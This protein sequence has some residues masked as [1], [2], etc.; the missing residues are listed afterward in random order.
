MDAKKLYCRKASGF[1]MFQDLNP[2]EFKFIR[3]VIEHECLLTPAGKKYINAAL[4]HDFRL[5]QKEVQNGPK[6]VVLYEFLEF[7]LSKFMSNNESEEVLNRWRREPRKTFAEEEGTIFQF[8]E[9]NGYIR[10]DGVSQSILLASIV[11][12]TPLAKTEER[13]LFILDWTSYL[14]KHLEDYYEIIKST[15][16]TELKLIFDILANELTSSQFEVMRHYIFKGWNTYY[17]YTSAEYEALTIAL[18]NIQEN[19]SLKSRINEVMDNTLF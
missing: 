18:R 2:A 7:T 15:T 19:S 6:G 9:D 3:F 4:V 8:L 16:G 13:G 12:N 14:E 10:A 1:D 5:Y 17:V 11:N